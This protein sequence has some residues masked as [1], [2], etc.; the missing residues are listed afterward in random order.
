MDVGKG[1]EST[2][3]WGGD[4]GDAERQ[5]RLAALRA[6]AGS[7]ENVDVPPP[8]PT[9]RPQAPTLLAQRQRA[10]RGPRPA[11]QIIGVGALAICVVVAAALVA[12]RLMARTP[13]RP[14]APD[15]LVVPVTRAG[16]QCLIR[17]SW[18]PDGKHIAAL[19]TPGA[20]QTPGNN[21]PSG[22]TF[23]VVYDAALTRPLQEINLDKA[24]LPQALPQ[25]VQQDPTLMQQTGVAY[26]NM[27][28]S[29]DGAKV[30]VMAGGPVPG[31]TVANGSPDQP[32]ND[33][34]FWALALVD[35][36]SGSVRVIATPPQSPTQFTGD[37]S[38]YSADSYRPSLAWRF[39]LT[40]GTATLASIPQALTYTWGADG[41]LSAAVPMPAVNGTPVDFLGSGSP[42]DGIFLYQAPSPCDAGL[43]ELI[44]T[45]SLWSP[46]GRYV[47]PML[48]ANGRLANGPVSAATATPVDGS[49]GTNICSSPSPTSDA[50]HLAPLT[51]PAA[52]T[53]ALSQT[54][55][56]NNLQLSLRG[57]LSPTGKRLAVQPQGL[58]YIP[59]VA[60]V[61]DMTT[62][63]LQATI[64]YK[65]LGENISLRDAPSVGMAW[66]P[67][68]AH[69]LLTNDHAFYVLGA[70]S[71]GG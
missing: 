62:G 51:A 4:T 45:A 1:H 37:N 44:L 12:L 34:F 64:T 55:V 56:P 18:S 14:P 57:Q 41:S 65:L 5:R 17:A 40:G 9:K 58:P 16:M 63:K 11:W 30:A 71:L 43:Y 2:A 49:G 42:W 50:A 36:E 13:P 8:K 27:Q 39:D 23:L 10:R 66:S 33:A 6:L 54:I 61:Y 7:P 28:W 29:S 19:M 53:N 25:S 48:Y 67:D 59:W 46:D 20:C 47:V 38:P 26:Y 70:R 60:R 31:V 68:G 52:L 69:L 24:I 15:P 35:V 22:G 32:Q 21:Q 3:R